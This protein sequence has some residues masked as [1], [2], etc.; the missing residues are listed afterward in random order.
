MQEILDLCLKHAMNDFEELVRLA[1]NEPVLTPEIAEEIIAF[2]ENAEGIPY[3]LDAK[4]PNK[5]D[6]DI[7][8]L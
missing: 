7:Y 4:F 2:F 6:Q 5:D 3:D 1:S 8:S